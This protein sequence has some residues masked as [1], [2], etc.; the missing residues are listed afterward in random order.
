VEKQKQDRLRQEK[1]AK[2]KKAAE[3]KTAQ[4]RKE[5][6]MAAKTDSLAALQ[7]IHEQE[8]EGISGKAGSQG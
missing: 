2:E 4:F 6:E 1:I 5:K 7:M 3:G 8:K